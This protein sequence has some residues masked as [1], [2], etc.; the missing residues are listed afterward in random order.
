[1]Y[2]KV[3]SNEH[4]LF[5][6]EKLRED[7]KIS[8]TA[9]TKG[10]IS[11]RSYTRFLSSDSELSFE[12]LLKL[13]ERLNLTVFD[14]G[15]YV[16][17]QNMLH[18]MDEIMFT[19]VVKLEQYD[20]AYKDF[21]PQI[22]HKTWRSTFSVKALPCAEIKMNYHLDKIRPTE[23]YHKLK[24]ILKIDEICSSRII[25]RED[26]EALFI[27]ID[28]LND[29][30]KH[31]IAKYLEKI[32]KGNIKVLSPSVDGTTFLTHIT[33]LKALTTVC[34]INSLNHPLIKES[35]KKAIDYSSRS[36]IAILDIILF[37]II[38]KYSKT[39]NYNYDLIL[40]GYIST[41]ISSLD[42][43]YTYGK[44]IPITDSDIKRFTNLL[45]DKDFHLENIYKRLMYE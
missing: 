18:N 44:K 15:S 22:E 17:N 39:Y 42:N 6:I 19:E 32:L 7:K 26:V 45:Q 38:F 11:R 4:F 28:L 21:Y 5:Y 13:I 43:Y 10:I 36:K 29:N 34:N 41:V 16:Y 31:M 14:F 23:A 33:L 1:M 12:V 9:L 20:V 8:I 40:F 3:Y 25:F 35:I 2:N 37:E 24:S 27:S 30:D